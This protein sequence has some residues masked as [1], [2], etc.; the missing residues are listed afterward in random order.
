MII[1]MKRFSLIMLC[2]FLGLLPTLRAADNNGKD[3][4]AVMNSMR[5]KR[6]TKDLD[7]T[8]DQQKKVMALLNE[9]SKVTAQYR[10]NGNLSVPER[11]AKIKEAQQVTY[12]KVK[13]LLTPP[14]LEKFEKLQA[15][16]TR[17]KKKN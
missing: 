1:S 9:E 11:S 4:A 17:T 6:L 5:L 7:L 14:Q 10:E 13:P 16:S 8:E 15:A 2:A 12:G 3:A